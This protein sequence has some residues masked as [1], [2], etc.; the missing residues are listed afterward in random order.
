MAKIEDIVYDAI[1]LGLYD[2]LLSKVSEL[3]FKYNRR[4]QL[5]DLYEEAL[6]DLSDSK[7]EISE[8]NKLYIDEEEKSYEN[9]S[10]DTKEL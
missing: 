3:R 10:K 2:E 7:P 8:I 4:V 5:S 1:D 9:G 6:N